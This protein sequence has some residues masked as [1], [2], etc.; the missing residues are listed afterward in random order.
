MC[1]GAVFKAS[2]N[3]ASRSSE[4]S[5]AAYIAFYKVHNFRFKWF[6][7]FPVLLALWGPF[8]FVRRFISGSAKVSQGM[9]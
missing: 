4:R 9:V 7:K 8:A 1:F 6:R 5:L 2:T 3:E